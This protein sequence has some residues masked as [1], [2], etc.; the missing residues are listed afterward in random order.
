MA[1]LAFL[2]SYMHSQRRKHVSSSSSS[3]ST[4]STPRKTGVAPK[5][6]TSAVTPENVLPEAVGATPA[7][8]TRSKTRKS[9]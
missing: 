5:D 4:H 3:R 7:R 8:S 9:E 2:M 6:I 1:A